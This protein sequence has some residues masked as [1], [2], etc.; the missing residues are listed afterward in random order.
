MKRFYLIITLFLIGNFKAQVN[1]LET[2]LVLQNGLYFENN[3]PFTGN[4]LSYYPQEQIKSIC[5]DY[6][7]A[8]LDDYINNK[9]SLETLLIIFTD[10]KSFDI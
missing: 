3:S 7:N 8:S 1:T 10:L 2:N 6:L 4:A 9:K 5:E